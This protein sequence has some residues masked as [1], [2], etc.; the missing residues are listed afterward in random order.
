LVIPKAET[1]YRFRCKVI[2]YEHH[3]GRNGS[4]SFAKTVTAPV[5]LALPPIG[6]ITG[7]GR[8]PNKATRSI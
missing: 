2:K 6:S 4:Y 7:A 5:E 1:P 3:S 8:S